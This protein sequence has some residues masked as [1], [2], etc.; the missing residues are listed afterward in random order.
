[1]EEIKVCPECETD[2]YLMYCC[3]NDGTTDCGACGCN[4][5]EDELKVKKVKKEN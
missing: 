4:W 2:A 5:E 3:F 1:M